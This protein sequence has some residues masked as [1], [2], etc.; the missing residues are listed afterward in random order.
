MLK[1]IY[2]AKRH[3]DFDREQFLIRWRQHGALATE[4]PSWRHTQLY[5]QSE[6]LAPAPLVRASNAYDALAVFGF[7]PE[8]FTE[9]TEADAAS[10]EIMIEDEL[11]TFAEPTFNHCLWVKQQ[12]LRD[13]ALGGVSA[14]LFYADAEEAATA[15]RQLA[16]E[17]VLHRVVLDLR[18]DSLLGADA[19]TLEYQ[20]VVECSAG[21]LATLTDAVEF[22]ANHADLLLM[23][24]DTVMWHG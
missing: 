7:A 17:N 15:G 19:Q 12:V 5:V 16:S 1:M 11:K 13:G 3:P 20:A 2:L 10:A 18:D 23:T 8:L 6:P 22:H 21:K 9:Q 14:Y 4:Q 24:R